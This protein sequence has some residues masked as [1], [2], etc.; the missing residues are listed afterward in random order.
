MQLGGGCSALSAFA[1]CRSPLRA[2]LLLPLQA[3]GRPMCIQHTPA[4]ALMWAALLLPQLGLAADARS[5]QAGGPATIFVGIASYRD[6]QCKDT[7]ADMF[8]KADRPE[9]I[10]VGLCEQNAEPEE[11]C[12]TEAL[13]PHAVRVRR[14]VL[15]AKQAAGPTYARYLASTLYRGEAFYLQLDSHTAF[16]RGWDTRLL[17]MHAALPDPP[18]AIVSAHPAGKD[19][20]EEHGVP[21]LCHSRFDDSGMLIT[22]GALYGKSSIPREIPFVAGGFLF[23]PADMLATCPFDPNLPELFWGEEVLHAARLWT[24]GYRFYAPSAN[25]VFH[26]YQRHT[27]PRFHDRRESAWYARQRAT[28]AKVRALL[29]GGLPGYRH[30]F[31][32][33]STVEEYLE[34]AR[35]DPIARTAESNTTF[36]PK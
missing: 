14:V 2:A 15:D 13:G 35:I 6:L 16:T 29:A 27:V 36:C 8:A 25:V 21:V 22:A 23:A 28:Q 4:V 12:V 5:L 20:P 7:L 26:D 1:C 32:R 31:G 9:H 11:A 10:F 33:N 17:A 19:T 24:H 3:L 18:H 30:G 34:F